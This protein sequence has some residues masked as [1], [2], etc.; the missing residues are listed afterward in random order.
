[1]MSFSKNFNKK[2]IFIFLTIFVIII[3]IASRA[4][5]SFPAGQFDVHIPANGSLSAVSNGLYVKHIITS[6]FLFKFIVVF[7][8]G[9]KGLFAGDY[10]FTKSQN[11]FSVAYRMVKGI[12]GLPK[13]KITI[14]E[15]T[16]VYDMAF[17][18][19]TKFP[20]FNGPR[21]VS[22]ALK[23]EGYLFPDTYFFLSNV[24]PEEVINTM[25]LNFDEKTKILKDKILSS[26]R[27]MN[28]IITMA[29]IVEEEASN[30]EDRKVIAGI[31]W[32]RLDKN[33]YLQV[34]APFYYLTAKRGNFSLDDLKIDSPYNTYKYKGLPKGP[35]SNPGLKSIMATIEPLSTSHFYYLTGKDGVMRYADTYSGH[36]S[37]KNVY[38][39]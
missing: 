37:N 24:R 13:I 34:D 10:R 25:R 29:S 18:Y 1:M 8:D 31:L 11:V 4:P 21:F 38:L 32:K 39:K 27:T 12:Q 35:I 36:L 20:Y 22:L 23:Y 26:N 6:P 15:G 9:Q 30:S 14:P 28:E 19:M 5:K 33:M 2:I 7:L 17:L 16:N 3:L